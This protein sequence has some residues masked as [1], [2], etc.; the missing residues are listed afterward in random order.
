MRLVHLAP[1]SAERAIRK[2][3]IRGAKAKFAT[4]PTTEIALTHAVYAMP[5]VA[6]YW[7]TLQWLRELRRGHD[8]RLIAVYFR[9]PDAEAVL[10]GRYSG[11]HTLRTATSAAAWVLKNP[12]GAQVVV[13]RS[14]SAKELVSI[15]TVKQLV[16]WTEIPEGS[17]K[18]GCVCAICLP[19]GDRQ[20]MRRVRAAF[21][22]GLAAARRA[23]TDAQL[24]DALNHL[25][26]PLERA[27][28]RLEHD[29]LVAYS[30]AS[31][32]RVRR[33]V[34]RLLGYFGFS[35]VK[36]DL[37]RLVDDPHLEVRREAIESLV[38]A[39][40]SARAA[41]V[42]PQLES[43]TLVLFIELLECEPDALV[44]LELLERF[45]DDP[46]PVIQAAVQQVASMLRPDFKAPAAARKRL[47]RLTRAKA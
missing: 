17:N 46:E 26:L 31:S 15:K 1:A 19:R 44:A 34:A 7:T 6:D 40:G 33:T 43:D 35:K 10:C 13:P 8:E 30:R 4:S 38:R 16:G 25:E 23:G 27:A 41:K 3:G 9:V 24:L 11:V 42:L 5:V 28:D 14:V 29:K 18:Y 37:Q 20:L 36:G 21:A 12:A 39:G 32:A 45:A 22:A 47:A 2:S